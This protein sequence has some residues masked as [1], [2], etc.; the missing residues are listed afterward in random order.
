VDRRI[1]TACIDDD[2]ETK[3]FSYAVDIIA[4]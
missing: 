1:D 2:F 3:Q 4:G